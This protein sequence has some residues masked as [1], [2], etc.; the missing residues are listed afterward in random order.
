M[1][2]HTRLRSTPAG[3]PGPPAGV[4]LIANSVTNS[5]ATVVWTAGQ[6]H[7]YPVEFHNIETCTEYNSTWV[8]AASCKSC[9]LNIIRLFMIIMRSNFTQINKC[10]HGIHSAIE[11]LFVLHYFVLNGSEHTLF[12]FL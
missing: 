4:Y 7:G 6:E 1:I 10:I 9:L 12:Y 2:V 11:L 5:S 3:P 8:V